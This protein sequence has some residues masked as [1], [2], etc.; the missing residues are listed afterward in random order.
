MALRLRQGRLDEAL[1]FVAPL[2]EPGR[3]RLPGPLAE[4]LSAALQV[5]ARPEARRAVLER[6]VVAAEQARRL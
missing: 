4:A 2:L 6:V 1:E 5:D 3:Q